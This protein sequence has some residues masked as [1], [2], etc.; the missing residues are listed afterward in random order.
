MSVNIANIEEKSFSV[1]AKY[2]RIRVVSYRFRETANINAELLDAN[3]ILIKRENITLT[4]TEFKNW[5]QTEEKNEFLFD[6]I[7]DKLDISIDDV[8]EPNYNEN[9]IEIDNKTIVK[10][11]IKLR[12][13]IVSYDIFNKTADIVA[14]LLD[15]SYVVLERTKLTIN[16]TDFINWK[17]TTDINS[18]Y[19]FEWVCGKLGLTFEG[20]E[21]EDVD[22][23]LGAEAGAGAEEG[24]E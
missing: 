7:R 4:K 24:E 15:S 22:N 12:I 20:L 21:V 5:E 2:L 3:N 14:Q 9:I 11:A 8:P 6:L 1:T 18:I 16:N 19:L 10:T 13:H 17:N 23:V